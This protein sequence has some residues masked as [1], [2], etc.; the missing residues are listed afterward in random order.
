MKGTIKT[1]LTGMVMTGAFASSTAMANAPEHASWG[2]HKSASQQVAVEKYVSFTAQNT[3]L[4]V[5]DAQQAYVPGTPEFWP[6]VFFP[7]YPIPVQNVDPEMGNK[8]Q[9]IA[10]LVRLAKEKQ[11]TTQVTYEGEEAFHSPMIA[12]IEQELSAASLR[13]FKA[14]FNAT[15]ETGIEQAMRQLQQQG[16]HQ[17]IVAGAETDVCV[18]QTVLG[19]KKMGFDVTVVSDAVFSTEHYTR[20]SFKRLQQ[21]GVALAKAD[22]VMAAMNGSHKVTLSPRYAIQ[23]RADIYQGDRRK[24]AALTFNFDTENLKQAEHDNKAAVTYRNRQW[25]NYVSYAFAP[26]SGM[27]TFHLN[28]ADKPVSTEFKQAANL[29]SV[30]NIAKV[31]KGMRKAGKNQAII[32]GVVTQSE[33]MRATRRLL[34]AGITPVILEDS[35]MGKYVDP[36]HYLDKVYDLGAVP[37]TFKITGYEM[38]AAVFN[39]DLTEQE[40]A[41]TQDMFDNANN[42]TLI[43]LMPRLR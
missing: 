27:A 28:A 26:A 42:Q 11:V 2:Y 38:T 30:D 17:V 22:E 21:A 24:M 41:A 40:I 31:I 37:S 23:S 33:L 13:H 16:I 7:E 10:D 3:A 1:L 6:T 34:A 32:S 35:L 29:Q 39:L 25:T 18:L 8:I 36:V 20:P 9:R 43:E 12:S 14:Y 15:K 19:L 4:L 5:I